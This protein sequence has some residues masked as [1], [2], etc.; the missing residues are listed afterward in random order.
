MRRRKAYRGPKYVALNPM[1]TFLGGMSGVH[2]EHLQKTN[3][4]NHSAMLDIV[5]G[6]GTKNTWDRLVGAINMALV[7]VEQGI[8]PEFAD[9]LIAGREAL[10]ACGLRSVE[11]G[12]F[13]FTGDEMRAMNQALLLHDTQ[14]ENVRAIDI[15]RA[16]NEVLRRLNHRINSTSVSAELAKMEKRA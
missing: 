12:R 9:E 15:D 13:A 11:K 7:M 6:R 2:A 3:I 16:A 4:I 8:G 10:L 14:L 1:V 5:Q